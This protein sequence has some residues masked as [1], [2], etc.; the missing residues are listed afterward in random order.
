MNQTPALDEGQE[1]ISRKAAKTQGFGIRGYGSAPKAGF[2]DLGRMDDWDLWWSNATRS[3]QVLQVSQ[4]LR[5]TRTSATTLT[6]K[7]LRLGVRSGQ[8]RRSYE[9]I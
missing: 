5:P 9:S 7:P 4:S 3:M 6:L 8:K 1:E 2:H